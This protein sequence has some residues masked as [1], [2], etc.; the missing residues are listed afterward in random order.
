MAATP[1]KRTPQA[2][3]T[4]L[5]PARES[6]PVSQTT[7][8]EELFPPSTATIPAPPDSARTV[9]RS[10]EPPHSMMRT[11][12]SPPPAPWEDEP[13]TDRHPSTLPPASRS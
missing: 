5:P 3:E 7:P 13:P 12:R 6:A 10:E 2:N 9:S 11:M 1:R 4:L 8:A